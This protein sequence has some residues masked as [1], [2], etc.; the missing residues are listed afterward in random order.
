MVFR[1]YDIPVYHTGKKFLSELERGHP[2]L[3]R[4]FGE[5]HPEILSVFKELFFF[6]LNFLEVVQFCLDS[7]ELVFKGCD[8][9]CGSI[10]LCGIDRPW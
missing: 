2:D 3:E 5:Y 10:V 8:F 6:G 7:S 9:S 1:H 4:V